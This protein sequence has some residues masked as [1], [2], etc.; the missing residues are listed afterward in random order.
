MMSPPQRRSDASI[1]FVS[2]LQRITVPKRISEGTHGVAMIE[3][4][5]LPPMKSNVPNKRRIADGD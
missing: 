3:S 2:Y 1:W 4:W 5:L